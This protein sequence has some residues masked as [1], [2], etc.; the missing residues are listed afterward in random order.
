[1]HDLGRR[2]SLV[3]MLVNVDD[4]SGQGDGGLGDDVGQA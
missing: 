2:T 3:I 1:M 4:D